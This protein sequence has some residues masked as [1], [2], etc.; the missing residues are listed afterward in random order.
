[1][2]PAPDLM[3]KRKTADGEAWVSVADALNL[4]AVRGR[5]RRQLL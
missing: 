5:E 1:M 4:R 3:L 2:F